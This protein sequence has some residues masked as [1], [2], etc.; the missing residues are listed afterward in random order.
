MKIKTQIYLLLIFLISTFVSSRSFLIVFDRFKSNLF[1]GHGKQN[2]KINFTQQ[3][4]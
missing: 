1:T 3:F 2:K 4:T